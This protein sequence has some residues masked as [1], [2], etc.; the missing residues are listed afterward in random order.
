MCGVWEWFGEGACVGALWWF[1]L[2]V[3]GCCGLMVWCLY[4]MDAIA[5]SLVMERTF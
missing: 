4:G 3:L 5:L 1:E 2:R